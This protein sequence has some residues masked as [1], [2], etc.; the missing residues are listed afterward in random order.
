MPVSK[1][2]RARVGNVPDRPHQVVAFLTHIV[3]GWN[4]ERKSRSGRVH[5]VCRCLVLKRQAD[6]LQMAFFMLRGGSL[7]GVFGVVFGS[8]FG[9]VVVGG[10]GFVFDF[11]GIC[12]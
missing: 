3:W 7:S 9:V 6:Y 8:G 5:C 11:G 2:R 12:R 10:S 1:K 4:I